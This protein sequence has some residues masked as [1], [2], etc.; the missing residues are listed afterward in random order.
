MRRIFFLLVL[1]NLCLL[2]ASA[3]TE[4]EPFAYR[5]LF[6]LQYASDPQISPDGE[7]VVYR[8]MGFDIM[9]DRSRGN[10]WMVSIDGTRNEKLTSREGNESSPRWSPDG[11]R[12][13]FTASSGEGNEIYIYWTSTGQTARITQLPHSPS[14]LSWSADGKSLA[15]SMHVPEKPPISAE[16]PSKPKGA[17]WAPEPRMTDRLKH[18]ADGKGYM[19]PGFKHIFVVPSSGGAARQVSSGRYNHEGTL[20]WSP[21]KD[22]VYCWDFNKKY[23]LSECFNP[24]L[25]EPQSK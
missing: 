21:D 6:D 12:I 22:E 15:F 25:E 18:E 3:Q 24:R 23:S 2:S 1:L 4:K 9:K 16:I 14:S 5:D 17:E 11:K 19:E 20:S 8:R 13:A 7:W 10:L